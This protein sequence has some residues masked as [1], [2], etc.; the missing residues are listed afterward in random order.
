MKANVNNKLKKIFLAVLALVML[1]S[2]LAFFSANKKA[3]ASRGITVSEFLPTNE[4]EYYEF[5]ENV[6]KKSFFWDN[7]AAI[8]LEN[9]QNHN[10][11]VLFYIQNKGYSLYDKLGDKTPHQIKKLSNDTIAI[12]LTNVLYSINI[13]DL[14]ASPQS[15]LSN[16]TPVSGSYFD[17]NASH[18]AAASGND[19]YLYNLSGL[20]VTDGQRITEISVEEL[21]PICVNENDDLFYLANGT[22]AL[23]R[24]N[25]NTKL[26]T[27]LLSSS[28]ENLKFVANNDYLFYTNGRD[29]YKIDLK[30]LNQT[31]LTPPNS[32]FDL[33]KIDTVSDI[34]FRENGLVITDS[35]LP[36]I[37]EFTVDDS[38]LEFTG[39]AI[40]S[41][42]TAYNRISESAKEIDVSYNS[43]AVLDSVKLTVIKNT[44][45]NLKSKNNFANYF[46]NEGVLSGLNPSMLALGNGNAMLGGTNKVLILDYN[47]GKKLFEHT[48]EGGNNIVSI[49]YQSNAYYA[50]KI[51]DGTGNSLAVY[52]IYLQNGE[53]VSEKLFSTDEI[54]N[55]TAKTTV[56]VNGNF[57]ITSSV[58]NCV[59]KYSKTENGYQATQL[60]GLTESGI[61]KLAT[62]LSGTLFMLKSNCVQ[63]YHN[64]TVYTVQTNFNGKTAKSFAMD[65][66]NKSVYFIFNGLENVAKTDNLPN[67]S[68]KNAVIPQ[69]FKITDTNASVSELKIY[70]PKQNA[71]VYEITK[72]ESTFTFNGLFKNVTTDFIKIC[73]LILTE[74]DEENSI[75][76]TCNL[77]VLTGKDDK[78]ASVMVII[79]DNDLEEIN[80][81]TPQEK[82]LYVTTGVNMYYIPIITEDSR[83]C[84]TDSNGQ[85]I[86]LDKK[87]EILVLNKVQSLE[88]VF[89]FVKV[90]V[91]GTE[92]FGYVPE[93][94]TVEVLFEDII[95]TPNQTLIE[96]NNP[97]AL[98]NALIVIALACSVF[99]TSFYFIFKKKD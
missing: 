72:S 68:L 50:T 3:S 40:A 96:G 45:E 94:Y 9:S 71:N 70:S 43:L 55:A 98:R 42:K 80:S 91:N 59:Y 7:N 90:N 2:I 28:S 86:R 27:E 37:Q 67:I 93:N 32:D 47:S 46:I 79:N 66:D 11:S 36:A 65:Y 18:L 49:T 19:V 39:F 22:R 17:L 56:D 77:S 97:H 24:F 35:T 21:T 57:Y 14:S 4:I 69:E 87:S 26:T 30:T 6:P 15:L 51:K 88:S 83:F 23:T 20:N 60:N 31:K 52:K 33:G 58:N 48:F 95:G 34:C 74:N 92:V 29:F 78:N 25:L 62:D 44:E 85:T 73:S 63:Y 5:N 16:S 99:G 75:E 12:A 64:Q 13:N 76:R 41:N 10:Y 84:L 61:L 8:I 1:S 82:T 54:Y 53:Y 81:V 89:Y 38:N